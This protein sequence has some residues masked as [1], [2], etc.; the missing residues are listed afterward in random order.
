[1]IEFVKSAGDLEFLIEWNWPI[2]E[3]LE[4]LQYVLRD[5]NC[6]LLVTKHGDI[7]DINS[8]LAK[9]VSIRELATVKL[10]LSRE[11]SIKIKLATGTDFLPSITHN[12]IPQ[13]AME[14]VQ[15]FSEKS[16]KKWSENEKWDPNHV[17]DVNI[18]PKWGR[19]HGDVIKRMLD[20]SFKSPKEATCSR[21]A[22]IYNVF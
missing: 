6:R 3:N 16:W 11:H 15:S 9:L 22:H 10:Q 1:M 13:D 7:I 14:L 20:T 17:G 8:A 18:S 19:I 21:N 4:F 12:S 2:L 5:N